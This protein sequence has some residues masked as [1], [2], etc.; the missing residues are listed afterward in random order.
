MKKYEYSVLTVA[1]GNKRTPVL[2][3]M[4]ENGWRLISCQEVDYQ[5]VYTFERELIDEKDS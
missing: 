5:V 3:K 2:N 4:G 1:D